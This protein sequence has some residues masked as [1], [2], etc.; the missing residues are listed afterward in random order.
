MDTAVRGASSL[1]VYCTQVQT[2]SRKYERI[3]MQR[4]KNVPVRICS[5]Q[6]TRGGQRLARRGRPAVK[7]SVSPPPFSG[8]ML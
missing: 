8:S 3:V 4:A 7:L 6:V 2:G 1:Q 5:L